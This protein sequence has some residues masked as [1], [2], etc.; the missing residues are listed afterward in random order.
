MKNYNLYGS[1]LLAFATLLAVSSAHAQSMDYGS[2]QTLFGEPVT[3]SATGTPQR[4]SEVPAN[5]TI[6]TADEIRQSGSRNIPEILSRV[7]GLDI[8][9]S[10][11]NSYDVGVRGFQQPYQPRLLVL[12]DGRQVFLDD[13]SRTLWDNI[14]VNIDDIRQI[15]VVKGASSALFG[16]NAGGGVINIVTYSPI[17]DKNNVASVGVGSQNHVNLDGTVTV[18][19][20]WGG[21]KISAG[22]MNSNPF[23][24]DIALGGDVAPAKPN[25]RYI[26]SNSVFQL[27]PNFQLTT[28]AN[29]SESLTT[30]A[31]PTDFGTI[32][33]QH[34]ITYSTGLG[35]NWQSAWGLI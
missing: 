27:N 2:L 33:N 32:G 24:S 30:T 13:Y 11:L 31:D 6:I 23:S 25:K 22:G 1:S 21:T 5:M 7:P 14:P 35:F 15:E 34:T 4:A 19:G 28:E 18:N 20:A 9:Q 26:V 8:F 29:Y 17:Y 12:V 16:S 3:T 10:S